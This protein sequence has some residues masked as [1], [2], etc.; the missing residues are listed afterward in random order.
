LIPEDVVSKARIGA[1]GIHR[2]KLPDYAG[3]E[4]IKQALL[5]EDKEIILS[6]H[7]L[8]PKIDQGG[9]ILSIKHPV[10]YDSKFTLEENIQR[11]RDEIAP[12]FPILV[13]ETL[14]HLSKK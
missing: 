6:A 12:L 10:N 7:H 11:L 5:K 1:F 8:I 4:P 9:I 13:F 3:S 14:E 2:G